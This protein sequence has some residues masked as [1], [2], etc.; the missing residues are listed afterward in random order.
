[1]KNFFKKIW[2]AVKTFFSKP[3]FKAIRDILVTLLYIAWGL[4][5][6]LL[7][8]Y[9]FSQAL[10][11]GIEKT[12][13]TLVALAVLGYILVALLA[14]LV[15]LDHWT[16]SELFEI[17]KLLWDISFKRSTDSLDQTLSDAEF[18]ISMLEQK[19]KNDQIIE[20]LNDI[21]SKLKEK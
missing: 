15:T 3:L 5:W 2:N 4:L 17:K 12:S 8:L 21:E 16:W 20:K 18:R 9:I 7:L 13:A 10:L 19:F 1:M 6:G 14:F 11:L